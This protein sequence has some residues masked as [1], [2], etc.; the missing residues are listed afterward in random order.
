MV[1]SISSDVCSD[2]IHQSWDES[3]NCGDWILAKV[4]NT[5]PTVLQHNTTT[6][7]LLFHP[8]NYMRNTWN[9]CHMLNKTEMLFRRC[10][11]PFTNACSLLIVMHAAL[12]SFRRPVIS[13]SKSNEM[14]SLNNTFTLCML[15]CIRCSGWSN[16]CI[17]Q[18]QITAADSYVP[19][20]LRSQT[21][22]KSGLYT[23]VSSFPNTRWQGK[24]R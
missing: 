11:G 18:N 1:P 3:S 14:K 10:I 5:G 13:L 19:A 23:Y 2:G 9:T 4:N 22:L 17:S 21:L 8:R 12:P 20:R 16:R 6:L 7:P 24:H 15:F